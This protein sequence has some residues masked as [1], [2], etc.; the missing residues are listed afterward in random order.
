MKRSHSCSGNQVSFARANSRGRPACSSSLIGRDEDLI[1][2]YR[3]IHQEFV[4]SLIHFGEFRVFIATKSDG[5]G[6]REPYVITAIRTRWTDANKVPLQVADNRLPGSVGTN[7]EAEVVEIDDAWPEF[8]SL[9]YD[10]LTDFALG[11]YCRLWSSNEKGFQS[12][13]RR[14]VGHWRRSR[15]RAILR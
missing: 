8:P 5:K 6:L 10:K 7:F 13:Y 15:W 11:V 12:R 3:W 9:S 2:Y 4:P 1:D 14:K